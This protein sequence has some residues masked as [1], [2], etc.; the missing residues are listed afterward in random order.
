MFGKQGNIVNYLCFYR[1][2]LRKTYEIIKTQVQILQYSVQKSLDELILTK[3]Y[4]L[5]TTV[6][7]TH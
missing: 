6:I 4:R 3:G 1:L 5:N 7:K 2:T